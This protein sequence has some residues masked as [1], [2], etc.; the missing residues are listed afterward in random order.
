[1]TEELA[2]LADRREEIVAREVLHHYGRG[3]VNRPDDEDV[4]AGSFLIAD[5]GAALLGEALEDL[6]FVPEGRGREGREEFVATSS[7]S[8]A[9]TTPTIPPE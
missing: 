5:T 9:R 2:A 3:A 8:S 7:L 4:G 6:R 1:M